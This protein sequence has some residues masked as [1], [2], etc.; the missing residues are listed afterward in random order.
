MDN[1]DHS[2][3]YTLRAHL[4]RAG[5]R[6]LMVI[7]VTILAVFFCFLGS[8]TIF[9]FPFGTSWEQL[10]APNSI[11]TELII[12]DEW[13]DLYV[14]T[15]DNSV[16]S[17]NIRDEQ[18]SEIHP[19]EV[20]FSRDLCSSNLKFTPPNPPGSIEESIELNLCGADT[21]L[22]VNY[23]LLSDGTIWKWIHGWGWLES[24][25]S[26]M[27]GIVF[28]VATILSGLT[29]LLVWNYRIATRQFKK[30]KETPGFNLGEDGH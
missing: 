9:T 23:V 18:C 13:G 30:R 14:E 21:V 10:P 26:L 1:L 8:Y 27:V 15:I 4:P 20:N 3:Q 25:M 24:E 22:Q 11:V 12:A 19:E 2:C 28:G 29:W 7:G 16:F 5:T 17:C 6:F